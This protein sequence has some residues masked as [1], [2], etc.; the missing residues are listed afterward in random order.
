MADNQSNDRTTG[1]WIHTSAKAAISA[2]PVVGSPAAEFFGFLVVA[3]ASKRK[4][5]WIRSLEERLVA[6]ESK[7]PGLIETLPS[8]DAFVTAAL[9]ATQVAMRSHQTEKLI[10]LRNAVLN[11]AVGAAPDADRQLTFL[12]WVDAFTPTHIAFL[13]ICAPSCPHEQRAAIRSQMSGRREFTDCV[14]IDLST[15][16]LLIDHRPYIARN[17]ESSSPLASL[18]WTLSEIGRQFLAF[19]GAPPEGGGAPDAPGPAR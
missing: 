12:T 7:I 15:R 1:D 17:R 5:E 18:E 14:V 8:N 3:P 19:I 10:A 2:V 13:E 4:D 6:L 9:H 16:G 11:V